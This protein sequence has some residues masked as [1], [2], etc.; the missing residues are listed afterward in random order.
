M[1][2]PLSI[3]FPHAREACSQ[4][5]RPWHEAAQTP[6]LLRGAAG[7]I[8]RLA[9]SYGREERT[10]A[11]TRAESPGIEDTTRIEDTTPFNSPLKAP[12]PGTHAYPRS[13]GDWILPAQ[14]PE[15][16]LCD[17]RPRRSSLQQRRGMRGGL[18]LQLS[19]A[20]A[21]EGGEDWRD[22]TWT[23]E[24]LDALFTLGSRQGSDM[25][26]RL[27]RNASG[28]D[29]TSPPGSASSTLS[30]LLAPRTADSVFLSPDPAE[31][32]HGFFS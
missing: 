18:F 17:K 7:P 32:G 22:D 13:P 1:P 21:D 12:W 31:H 30:S 29:L 8:T 25:C 15:E 9:Q 5:A 6:L 26:V 24:E 19:G 20:G 27:D 28:S 11:D 4:T 23:T 14:V 3:P 2:Y 10:L 16:E